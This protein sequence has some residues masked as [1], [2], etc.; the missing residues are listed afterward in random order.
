MNNPEEKE[1]RMKTL[2][3]LKKFPE[4]L[5][6]KGVRLSPD[7]MELAQKWAKLT[8]KI[9]ENPDIFDPKKPR[10]PWDPDG[11]WPNGGMFFGVID[12]RLIGAFEAS[13]KV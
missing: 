1:V 4:M 3:Y 13:R 9:V 12:V 11:P 7:E 5:E 6:R 10:I 8:Y 2:E